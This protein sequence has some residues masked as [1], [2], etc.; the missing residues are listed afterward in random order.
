MKRE[1]PQYLRRREEVM[2]RRP[3]LAVKTSLLG[4][5]AGIALMP[6]SAQA[7]NTVANPICP[8]ETANFNPTLPPSINVPNGYSVSVFAFGL[9]FPTGLAFRRTGGTFEV[10]VLESGHGLPS[11]AGCNDEGAAAVGGT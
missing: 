10:Y 9:N 1:R 7:N 2:S 4:C 11:G 5:A 3:R 6:V 8:A